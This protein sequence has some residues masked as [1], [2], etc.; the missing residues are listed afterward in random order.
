MIDLVLSR[1]WR[2]P[3]AQRGEP[4]RGLRCRQRVDGVLELLYLQ[5]PRHLF[6]IVLHVALMGRATSRREMRRRRA[7][8]AGS[9]LFPLEPSLVGRC[10]E[11]N[12]PV[13]ELTRVDF[14][15]AVQ[16]RWPQWC[17]QPVLELL[18]PDLLDFEFV[19][20]QGPG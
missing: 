8:A 20:A 10:V 19:P 6:V 13:S 18:N 11:R 17:T 3:A 12:R 9:S 4:T 14:T 1:W 5:K 15:S 7:G 16:C 2:C